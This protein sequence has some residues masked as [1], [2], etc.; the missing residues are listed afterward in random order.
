V[1][2]QLPIAW[3]ETLRDDWGF[4]GGLA[5][6]YSDA[7]TSDGGSEVFSEGPTQASLIA[8]LMTPG[9]PDYAQCSSSRER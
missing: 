3:L 2:R 8:S 9:D 5:E 1:P 4:E 6:L 7:A